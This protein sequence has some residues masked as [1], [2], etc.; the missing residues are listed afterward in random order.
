MAK[1]RWLPEVQR[2]DYLAVLSAGAYGY[3]MASNYNGRLRA[4]EVLV[5]GNQ[6]RIIRQRETIEQLLV[7]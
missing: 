6:F 3:A 2:G 4:P 1:D 5:N 7:K